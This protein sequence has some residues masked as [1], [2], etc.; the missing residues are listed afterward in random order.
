MTT[1]LLLY[2]TV[3]A[4]SFGRHRDSCVEIGGNYSFSGKVNSVPLM[5]VEFPLAAADYAIVFAGT[6]EGIMPAVIL[7]LRGNENLYL[8]NDA[9]WEAK[10][11]SAFL[12][13]SPIAFSP[14]PLP[15]RFRLCVD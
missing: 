12:S 3:V 9:T 7:G 10:N 4:L 11:I 8:S 15:Q 1:Q 6:K 14:S 2:E 5:A 13:P